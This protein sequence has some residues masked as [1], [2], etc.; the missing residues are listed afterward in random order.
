MTRRIPRQQLAGVR[1]RLAQESARLMIEHGIA[2]YRLAKRKAAERFGV[3]TSGVLPSNAQIE[4]CVAERQRLFEPAGHEARLRELRGCAAALMTVLA[5]FEPRLAGAVLNGTATVSAAIEV[6]AFS[7]SVE[8]VADRLSAEGFGMTLCERRY[9]F[10]GG[11]TATLPGFRVPVRGELAIVP[12]F[13]EH[14]LR[15]PPLSAVDQRPMRRAPLRDVRKL[16]DG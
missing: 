3:T 1:E 2:D 9:R 11:R 16:L 8:A 13:P 5:P 12:V 6:H 10:G 7:P 4:A 14:G 15:E